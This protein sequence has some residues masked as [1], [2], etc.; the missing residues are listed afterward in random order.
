MCSACEWQTNYVSVSAT[1]GKI[2][3]ATNSWTDKQSHKEALVFIRRDTLILVPFDP[4]SKLILKWAQRTI[5]QIASSKPFDIYTQNVNEVRCAG[6]SRHAHTHARAIGQ[7]TT[8]TV[9]HYKTQGRQ[10]QIKPNSLTKP[11][12]KHSHIH[13]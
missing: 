1:T 5:I 8:Q 2:C 3:T 10:I 13:K 12:H 6:P 11:T 7:S 9:S 4:C